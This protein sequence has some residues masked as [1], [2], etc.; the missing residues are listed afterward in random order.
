[1]KNIRFCLF[2]LL[3]LFLLSCN[4]KEAAIIH[5]TVY[6]ASDEIF[7]KLNEFR[8][9]LGNLNTTPGAVGGRREIN[10]DGIPDSLLDKP[11]SKKFFN[12]V[13]DGATTSLQRGFVYG[14]GD[15]QASA[16]LF[17]HV[18]NDAASEFKTFSGNKVFANVSAIDWPVGFEVAGQAT[19]ATVKAFGM[20]FADVDPANSV[21]L[22]FFNGEKS[23]GKFFVPAQTGNSKFSFLG[24]SFHNSQVSSVKVHHQGRLTDGGRDISQGGQHDLVV[25]DDLIYSEPVKRQN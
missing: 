17:S 4:K 23:L 25:I 12:P 11:L 22:E 15:F 3:G 20:V 7:S 13:G 10:W 5:Y 18:N 24:V 2:S 6:E 14:D 8:N 21:S 1:M 19:P 16:E 9:S